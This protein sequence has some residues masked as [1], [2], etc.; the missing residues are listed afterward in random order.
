MHLAS[1][2]RSP[3]RTP[4]SHAESTSGSRKSAQPSAFGNGRPARL[5]RLLADVAEAESLAN[6]LSSPRAARVRLSAMVAHWAEGVGQEQHS[7]ADC[8]LVVMAR[9]LPIGSDG[10]PAEISTRLGPEWIS[11]E[12]LRLRLAYL[13]KCGRS[14]SQPVA[15]IDPAGESSWANA[16]AATVTKRWRHLEEVVAL[17]EK[18]VN[19]QKASPSATA[20]AADEAGVCSVNDMRAQVAE[21]IEMQELL[22]VQSAQERKIMDLSAALEQSEDELANARSAIA[23]LSSTMSSMS[24]SPAAPPGVQRFASASWAS[25][26]GKQLPLGSYATAAAFSSPVRAGP[27]MASS[28]APSPESVQS[29]P[30]PQMTSALVASPE[31]AIAVSAFSD[32]GMVAR[33]SGRTMPASITPRILHADPLPRVSGGYTVASG[34]NTLR[35][36][37]QPGAAW[38]A[39]ATTPRRIASASLSAVGQGSSPPRSMMGSLATTPRTHPGDVT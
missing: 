31:S 2:S 25:A 3:R 34:E 15:G 22:Q 8:Q 38:T 11:E 17:L 30:L 12:E 28:I 29:T 35:F 36:L 26:S 13:R 21:V 4:R 24:G 10:Q 16:A 19:E 23:Q 14:G 7:H 33:Q 18:F 20:S 1:S 32:A 6:K 39:G 27:S 5:S 9:L 37:G